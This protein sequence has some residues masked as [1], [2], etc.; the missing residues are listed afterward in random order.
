MN[1]ISI[2]IFLFQVL[3]IPLSYLLSGDP[4]ATDRPAII[5]VFK[6]RSRPVFELLPWF[7]HELLQ[8]FSRVLFQGWH[9]VTFVVF[10]FSGF[11]QGEAGAEARLM[12]FHP[13]FQHGALL[14]VVGFTL[15]LIFLHSPY[16]FLNM[17][18]CSQCWSSGRITH[19]PFYFLSAGIPHCGLSGSPLL[20]RHQRTTD[21]AKQSLF[22]EQ[23]SWPAASRQHAVVNYC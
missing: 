16:Y 7:A 8:N 18:L 10:V 6:T 12:Q 13:N 21:F 20:P 11:V 17:S 5:A 1:P 14:T 9:V 3:I 22:T 19:V 4:H 15:N 2:A 23:Q